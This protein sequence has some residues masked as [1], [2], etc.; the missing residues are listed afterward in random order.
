VVIAMAWIVG[1]VAWFA[2]LAVRR[3]RRVS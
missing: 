2:P 3:Y 1:L